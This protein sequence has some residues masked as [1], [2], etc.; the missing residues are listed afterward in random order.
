MTTHAL[1]LTRQSPGGPVYYIAACRYVST[2]KNEFTDSTRTVINTK[3]TTDC[4]ACLE[5][6]CKKCGEPAYQT[7]D[8][9][10]Y[11]LC[12][13]HLKENFAAVGMEPPKME[14]I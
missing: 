8:G 7:P 3:R 11:R 2:D 13:R 14:T 10:Q 5:V 9:Y 12:E 4:T 6:K 1:R